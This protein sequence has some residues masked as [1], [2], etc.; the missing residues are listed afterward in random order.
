MLTAVGIAVTDRR[1]QPVHGRERRRRPAVNGSHG[2]HARRRRRT[3]A[4][5]STRAGRRA[6]RGSRIRRHRRPRRRRSR[7][8]RRGRAR[9]PG[10]DRPRPRPDAAARGH[11]R[12]V[13][14]AGG[15]VL[16]ATR[17]PAAVA[18]SA[19]ARTVAARS[20]AEIPVLTPQRRSTDTANAAP[21]CR[22]PPTVAIGGI[23]SSSRRAPVMATQTIPVVSRTS[24][25]MSVVSVCSAAARSA[26]DSPAA[27]PATSSIS[28]TGRPA[29]RLLVAASTPVGGVTRPPQAV[30]R[31]ARRDGGRRRAR[32]TAPPRRRR[33]A[34]APPPEARRTRRR[35]TWSAGS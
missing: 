26:P 32:R 29:A 24:S 16:A 19:S 27:G 18:G 28:S 3:R 5:Q 25:D 22:E 20:R 2:P 8:P 33:C 11:R 4:R 15:R 35:R 1:E 34:A 17:S 7:A 6:R 10:R 13:P 9:P 23:R 12:R 21:S 14:A 30:A 31:R